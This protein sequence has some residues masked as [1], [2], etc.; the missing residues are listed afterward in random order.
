MKNVLIIAAYCFLDGEMGFSRYTYIAEQ[1]SQKGCN[2]TLVT[3]QFR[4]YD[5]SH[6]PMEYIKKSETFEVVLLHEC[7]YKKNI[8]V[9]RIISHKQL[10]KSLRKY[11][12]NKKGVFDIVYVGI[13]VPETGIVAAEF[14]KKEKI[15]FVIDVMDIWPE[16]MKMVF[17]YPFISDLIFLPLKNRVEKVYASADVIFGV[18][19]TYVD[20]ALSSNEKAKYSEAIYIG[21]ELKYFDELASENV[22]K[23]SKKQ[24]EFWIVYIGTLGHSYDIKTLIKSMNIVK[25]QFMYKNLKLLI[26]GDGP[27][28]KEYQNFA[29]D[30]KVPAIF[31]GFLSYPMM[32]GYLMNS[33]VA[34]NSIKKNAAQSIVTK[35]GDYMAAGLP[36][37]NG[38]NNLEFKNMVT[39]K[40]IGLNYISEDE[41]SLAKAI[42]Y[43]YDDSNKRNEMRINSRK[44]SEEKFDRKKTYES[45]YRVI[46]NLE[47]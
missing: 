43:L 8:D 35:V 25:E 22:N 37:L 4:H 19:Q 5:K 26:L 40:N 1:L 23:I 28:K 15:P 9:K 20:R 21:T 27:L 32:I 47:S 2:V 7:G 44:L 12:S 11:L 10:A 45:I 6:R 34:V 29:D 39:E 33:D 31:T 17:D 24:D 41:E 46:L 16:A 38:S 30:L 18:S 13:P 36:I 14:A 42:K 3:S